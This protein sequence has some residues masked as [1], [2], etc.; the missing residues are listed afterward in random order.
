M[1]SPFT[2]GIVRRIIDRPEVKAALARSQRAGIQA[3]FQVVLQRTPSEVD[4]RKADEFL[5]IERDR[6]PAIERTQRDI[7]A[8]A[9]MR[10]KELL[11]KEQSKTSTAARAA[12][13]NTGVLEE[14][15]ALTPWES[16]V[17]ALLYCNEATYL[18]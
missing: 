12:V 9:E 10:A 5:R 14:R 15:T 13:L 7:L 4:L 16:F 11:E 3:V 1:N 6:Q 8:K 18:Q 2:I 17:Q